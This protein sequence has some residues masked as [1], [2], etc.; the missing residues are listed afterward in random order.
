MNTPKVSFHAKTLQHK[1]LV[2]QY[3]KLLNDFLPSYPLFECFEP[4]GSCSLKHKANVGLNRLC[5]IMFNPKICTCLDTVEPFEDYN[6]ND[7][8]KIPLRTSHY[9]SL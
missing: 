7:K 5:A 1:A 4:K 3:S 6:C 8:S 9:Y 2:L